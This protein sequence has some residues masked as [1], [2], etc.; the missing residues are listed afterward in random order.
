VN[1]GGGEFHAARRP[2]IGSNRVARF[3]VGLQRRLGPDATYGVRMLNGSPALLLDW[4]SAPAH[5][6]QRTAVAFELDDAGRL[7]SIYAVLATPKLRA[8]HA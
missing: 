2:V 1:D 3:L 6:A 5:V 8:L 4:P 7:R